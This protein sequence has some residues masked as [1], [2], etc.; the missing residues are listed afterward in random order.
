MYIDYTDPWDAGVLPC[1]STN[2]E[3]LDK[4]VV[5]HSTLSTVLMV[6]TPSSDQEFLY[7][8]YLSFILNTT[9]VHLLI[10]LP[11]YTF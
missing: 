3:K 8:N 1:T 9:T 6:D 11:K 7:R 4:C 10:L 2:T 5:S